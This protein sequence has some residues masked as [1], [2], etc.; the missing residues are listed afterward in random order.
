MNR[1][2]RFIVAVFATLGFLGLATLAT[3]SAGAVPNRDTVVGTHDDVERSLVYL[4]SEAEGT[5]TYVD[6]A[7]QVQIS[8]PFKATMGFCTGWFVSR[9]GHIMTAGHCPDAKEGARKSLM[10]KFLT[11]SMPPQD[12]NNPLPPFF[13]EEPKIQVLE[14]HGAI[15]GTD[16]LVKVSVSQMQCALGAPLRG[17][18]PVVA[19]VLDYRPLYEGDLA[20]LKID[21]PMTT[22]ALPIAARSPRNGD[23]IVAIG[24][25]GIVSQMMGELGK[26]PNQ[27]MSAFPGVVSQHQPPDLIRWPVIE[28]NAMMHPGMSGGP[29]VNADGNVIGTVSWGLQSMGGTSGINYATDTPS[30]RDFLKNNRVPFVDAGQP[31]V[32]RVH[33]TVVVPAT[34]TPPAETQVTIEVTK[35]EVNWSRYAAIMGLLAIAFTCLV[36]GTVRITHSRQSR[37]RPP[38]QQ[39][40][41]KHAQSV[42]S[43]DPHY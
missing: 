41:A 43:D 11:N 8:A 4:S 28:T 14:A 35:T 9:V 10:E 33:P 39:P 31:V 21:V 15:P 29:V 12:P 36:V 13:M 38:V 25:P 22:P 19:Q 18:E 40:A 3:P 26:T 42:E 6:E 5:V 1:L 24:Y 17:L 23:D 32:T 7:G 2:L 27:C 34:S 30:V 20:L 16:P 37:K